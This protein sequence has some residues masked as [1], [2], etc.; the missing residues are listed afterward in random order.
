MK[1]EWSK[2]PVVWHDGETLMVSVVFTWQLPIIRRLCEWNHQAG[3]H[4]RVG[5]VAIDLIPSFLPCK[6]ITRTPL[7]RVGAVS[8]PVN[9]VQ[10]LK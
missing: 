5:G 6:G 7:L 2:H 3:K 8:V 9:F 10:C 4:I 1:N